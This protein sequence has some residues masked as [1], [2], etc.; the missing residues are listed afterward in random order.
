MMR[1]PHSRRHFTDTL[2]V[3]PRGAS[4]ARRRPRSV[5]GAQAA[6]LSPAEDLLKGSYHAR[7]TLAPLASVHKPHFELPRYPA[8]AEDPVP[9]A[10][11]VPNESGTLRLPLRD[12][13]WPLVS[14]L[15]GISARLYDDCLRVELLDATSHSPPLACA[16]SSYAALNAGPAPAPGHA[17]SRVQARGPYYVPLAAQMACAAHSPSRATR[18]LRPTRLE[19]ARLELATSGC[20][21]R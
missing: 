13:S 19:R 9:G 18:G 21:S 7:W 15:G 8:R 5:L 4:W 6:V 10:S 3:S 16:T 2:G 20:G 17:Y 1:P 14:V 11:A 12:A